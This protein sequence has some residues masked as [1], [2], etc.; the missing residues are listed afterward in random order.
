MHIRPRS[1]VTAL[2]LLAALAA[3][4]CAKPA[5]YD[6]PERATNALVEAARNPGDGRVKTVLGRHATEMLSSGDPVYDEITLKKFVEAYDARHSLQK[7]DDGSV[8]LVVGD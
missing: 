3:S 6:S 5:R 2:F 4:G 1:F 8:T 7:N